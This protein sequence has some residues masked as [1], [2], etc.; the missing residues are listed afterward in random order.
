MKALL[1][2]HD[3]WEVVEKGYDEIKDKSA[4]SST[5]K[6]SL[7]DSRKKDKKALFL[8]YQALYD[9]GFE[10]ISNAATAKKAWEKI[11]TSY[12]GEEKVKQVRL[13]TLRGEFES[14]SM[15]ENVLVSNYCS[16]F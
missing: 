10:K 3:V 16:R 12:Q 13:Q 8:I 1:R 7:K 5:Q 11:Q 9:D 15:K 4:I 6:D 14:L 2:A